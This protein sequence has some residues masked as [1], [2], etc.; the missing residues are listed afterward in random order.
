MSKGAI[1]VAGGAGY[2]GSHACKALRRAG[3]LPVTIDNL[4][5]GHRSSVRWGPLIEGDIRDSAL[6]RQTVRQFRIVG[7][8]HFAALSSV[9]E[10]TSNPMRYYETNLVGALAFVRAL[11]EE[12]VQSFVFSSTAA[13]Y[14]IPELMPIPEIGATQPIN[15]YGETKLAFERAL[16]CL[17]AAT[18][19]RWAA[20]RYFNA[21]GADPDGEI[22]ER[23]EPETHL[24][25]N[26]A[27]AV[28]GIGPAL[29]LYGTDYPTA[30]GTAIR[31]YIHVTDLAEA[32]VLVIEHLIA[33]GESLTMN[34]GTSVGTSILELIAGAERL[35]GRPVPRVLRGRRAGDPPALVADA[36]LIRRRF[37]W[38]P[39]HS[40]IETIVRTAVAWEA[41]RRRPVAVIERPRRVPDVPAA[42]QASALA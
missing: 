23:H 42:G 25:P 12:Q 35:V 8:M 7:A 2:I 34:V 11:L 33:G 1:L 17:A 20:L 38:K 13:V 15:P 6:V 4:S 5:S 3:Y 29:H 31:D 14:G 41:N 9:A 19:L 16:R 26:I 21:A 10:S 30:D 28:L 36:R 37:G 18:P 27:R 39:R 32:H 40:A 22:G 24:V